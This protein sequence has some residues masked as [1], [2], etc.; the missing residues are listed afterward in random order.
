M[1]SRLEKEIRLLLLPWAIAIGAAI[2]LGAGISMTSSVGFRSGSML[3]SAYQFTCGASPFI[4]VGALV[5]ATALSFGMEFHYRTLPLLATQPV[6]RARIWREKMLVLTAMVGSGALVACVA[7]WF[8]LWVFSNWYP[9]QVPTVSELK[10]LLLANG[11]FLLTTL[12]GS[13]FWSLMAR[14]AIGGLMLNLTTQAASLSVISIVVNR[15]FH[16]D[17]EVFRRSV[18][19]IGL[20]YSGVFLWL[21]RWKFCRMEVRGD[22][23]ANPGPKLDS[24][25]GLTLKLDWLRCRPFHPAF[26]LVRKELRLNKP[27]FFL[28]ALFVLCWVVTILLRFVSPAFRDHFE[29]ILDTATAIVIAA[30]L[31]L[32]GCVSLGEEKTL[33]LNAWQLTLPVSARS[34]WF[35][36]LLVALTSVV[37]L[38]FVLPLFL[39]WATAGLGRAGLYTLITSPGSSNDRTILLLIGALAFLCGFWASTLLP[40][41][42]TAA[43]TGFLAAC[44][45]GACSALAVW[46]F[47]SFADD[48]GNILYWI[49]LR[50]HI[51]ARV[52]PGISELPLVILGVAIF[53]AAL[54]WQSYAHFRRPYMRIRSF[55]GSAAILAG[56]DFSLVFVLLSF[57]NAA[58]QVRLTPVRET[59]AAVQ[60][61]PAPSETPTQSHPRIVSPSEIERSL[62]LSQA[63]RDYLIDK[64]IVI[65]LVPQERPRDKE[66]FAVIV[67]SS[68]TKVLINKFF[69][70][71]PVHS[72]ITPK[73]NVQTNKP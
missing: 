44:G 16:E 72:E 25:A 47:E 3:L 20:V 56:V 65:E 57:Y 63:T 68:K 32:G 60:M 62:S 37:F 38:G 26:N 7:A 12:C 10:L 67:R 49:L 4:L 58:D 66:L 48:A 19:S 14:S 5:I 70:E 45:L 2:Y 46:C 30:L 13:A 69:Y 18:F 11:L 23:A 17:M 50:L 36:K 71:A 59:Q 42:V 61:L 1:R 15:F 35:I 27:L 9:D 55:V 54:L 29:I 64:E 28:G 73:Q 22:F 8:G 39:S 24:L 41:T 51:A 52:L 43:L 34:Q 40:N 6:A 31:L 33:G 21:G 53:S